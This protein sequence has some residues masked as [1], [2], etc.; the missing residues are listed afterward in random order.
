MKLYVS[1]PITGLPNKN[2]D[3][4]N[5]T[6]EKLRNLGFEVLNPFDLDQEGFN[7]ENCW[8][9]YLKRD[10]KELLSCDALCLLPGWEESKGARLEVIVALQ[11][12]LPLFRLTESNQLVAVHVAH[13]MDLIPMIPSFLWQTH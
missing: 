9:K 13:D 11:L 5:T 8:F 10:L 12:E 3:Q 1:G 7:P 4:F 2:I 6:S